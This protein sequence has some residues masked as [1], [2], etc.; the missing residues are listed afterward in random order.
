MS[1]Y[2]PLD[3][4]GCLKVMGY[5]QNTKSSKRI[6]LSQFLDFNKKCEKNRKNHSHRPV[7]SSNPGNQ[8]NR[9]ISRRTSDCLKTTK[10]AHLLVV[11][12]IYA[13]T[14]T[15]PNRSRIMST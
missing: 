7:L 14:Q 15:L 4:S 1:T 9:R 11:C 2:V 5:F 13:Q 8:P 3:M 6:V 10:K 12:E